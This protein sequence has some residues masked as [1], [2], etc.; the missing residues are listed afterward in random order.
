M[1][2]K[3]ARQTEGTETAG[4]AFPLAVV[5]SS[6]LLAGGV[7]L[8]SK[9]FLLPEQMDPKD[10]EGFEQRSLPP[11][12]KPREMP[13]G[14][15][16]V[17]KIT[18]IMPSPIKEYKSRIIQMTRPGDGFRFCFPMTAVIDKAMGANEQE[19]DDQIGNI[20]LIKKTGT[21]KSKKGKKDMNLFEVFIKPGPGKAEVR[22]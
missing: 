18:G 1:A 15:M 6:A 11:I 10:F 5:P 21:Q 16:L 14:A 17:G 20:L 2:K 19:Q 4:S 13:V 8:A 12:V 3:Q 9:A 7:A 22:A